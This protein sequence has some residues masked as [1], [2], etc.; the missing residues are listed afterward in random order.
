MKHLFFLS[1]LFCCTLTSEC[2]PL[3]KEYIEFA[4]KADTALFNGDY[5]KAISL[6]K[7]AF[8]QN[9]GMAKVIHRYKLAA[10]FTQL[11][12]FD[13]A[14]VQLDRIATK[15]KFKEYDIIANDFLFLPLHEDAR[16]KAILEKVRLNFL[17]FDKNK[18]P[19]N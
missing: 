7:F 11:N 14:F 3:P 9:N 6:Y 5:D 1:L 17:E 16:W 19:G 10:A 18:P 2:Q 4:A 15:G 13:S 8:S 12:L